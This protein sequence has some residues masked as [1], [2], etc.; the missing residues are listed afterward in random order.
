MK[1]ALTGSTGTIGRKL[2]IHL[3][4]LGHEVI[5]VSYRTNNQTIKKDLTISIKNESDIINKLQDVEII[6][7]LA[8]ANISK[9]WTKKHKNEILTSRTKGTRAILNWFFQHTKKLKKV[10]STSAI[11]IYP[12]P[13]SELMTESSEF[14]EGFLSEVC[15]EWEASTE[16]IPTKIEVGIVRV[17]L[18]LS[19]EAGIYP[20]SVLTKNIGI[21]PITGSK[22]NYWSWIHI[23]DLIEIYTSMVEGS[24]TTRVYNG[25][26]PNPV[27]QELY[28][29][30]VFDNN[31]QKRLI[32]LRFSPI[33][34]A[35]LLKLILGERS[36]LTH[37][38]QN[39]SS[40]KLLDSGFEFQF[41]TITKALNNLINE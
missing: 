26:A 17:G 29:K 35:F 33:I 12:D 7:H 9:P 31:K 40:Q 10:I 30:S 37:T 14:G 41:P 4:H 39:V 23:D 22:E 1:I 8:G 27:K 34:P 11:G 3:E 24:L 16:V 19:K 2:R 21:I 36:K 32:P 20:I 15:K 38:S 25:V 5:P 18:V 6:I 13:S 28:V